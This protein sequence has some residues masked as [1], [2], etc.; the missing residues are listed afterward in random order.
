VTNISVGGRQ[1]PDLTAPLTSRFAD[2]PGDPFAA[3]LTVG[4]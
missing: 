2:N 4:R 3:C 1:G